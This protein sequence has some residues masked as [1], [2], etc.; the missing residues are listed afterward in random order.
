VRGEETIGYYDPDTAGTT[1]VGLQGGTPPYFWKQ[2]IRLTQDELAEYTGWDL[3]AVNVLHNEDAFEHWGFIE[4]YGEGTPTNPGS[5]LASI[6]YHFEE[7]AFYRLDLNESI[8]I[9]DHNELWLVCAWESDND[10]FPG[11]LDGIPAVDGKGDHIY[12]NS[13]WQETQTFGEKFDHNWCMEGIVEGE[14]KAELSIINVK[15]P[16]GVNAEIKNAGEADASNLEYTTTVTGGILKLINKTVPGSKTTLA[17]GATEAIGSG[18]I[19]GFGKIAIEITANAD[20]AAEVVVTKSAFVLGILVI[21]I[22]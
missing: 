1:G 13:M 10:D 5:L 3:I 11:G 7:R 2:G 4:V 15:G 18:L 6:P 21:G 14:G 17:P 22:K 19:L 12:M 16:I 8:A 20:N 9:D